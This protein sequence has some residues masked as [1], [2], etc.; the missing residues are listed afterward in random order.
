[1]I[2]NYLIF[3]LI[4]II[5]ACSL[6]PS[7]PKKA[8]EKQKTTLR[9]TVRE[10]GAFVVFD[11]G[12]LLDRKT[13]LLWATKDNGA[14]IS[15]LDADDFCRGFR[16]AGYDDWRLP[17]LTEL[18]EVFDTT[19]DS[20]ALLMESDQEKVDTE[21]LFEIGSTF[22]W[23][24]DWDEASSG[25][26]EVSSG[27]YL[28][29]NPQ[30][31]DRIR[32]LPVRQEQQ[33]MPNL[34]FEKE[35]A[36]KVDKD[37]RFQ[38]KD[39]GTIWDVKTELMWARVDNGSDIDWEAARSYCENLTT[40]DYHDWRLPTREEL[41]TLYLKEYSY[42]IPDQGS[43]VHIIP[44]IKLTSPSVWSADVIGSNSARDYS[45][46][47]PTTSHTSKKNKNQMRVLPV[48]DGK[49]VSENK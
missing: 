7:G 38:L 2:R 14:E 36:R 21:I 37:E 20:Y 43:D 42:P 6:N 23:A 24:Q 22:L 49:Q 39:D 33:P 46:A 3:I 41:A 44:T 17:S 11:D 12:T 34:T 27:E 16:L 15:R 26:F 29:Q 30:S 25:F 32:F 19:R 35:F 13:G 28:F 48:R 45:F 1:M 31:R 40:G 10:A 4:A 18:S 9:E 8:R 5:A 47:R